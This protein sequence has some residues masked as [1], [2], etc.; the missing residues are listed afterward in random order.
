MSFKHWNIAPL[1]KDG[2]AALAEE[3]GIHPFLA[4]MLTLRGI[5]T[6]QEASAYLVGGEL[7]DD[8]F[9]FADMDAAVERI[10]RALDSGER[11]AVYGDYD[12]DGVTAT[13]LLYSFLAKNGADVLYYIPEREGEGYGMH[14][15]SVRTLAERGVR[16]II[17]VD[18][19][20]SAGEE[21]RLAAELGVDVV[22][23]DHHMPP[24][25]LPAAVAVVD[26][27]RAD[28]GSRCKDYAGVGVA[29]KLICALDGD[30]DAMRE[31][32]ADL[33]AL[34]TLAD[35]MPLDGENRKLV[36]YGLR[37]LT[38][39]ARP[40]LKQLVRVAGM[41]GRELDASAAAFT[42]APRI[43]AAGRMGSP[44]AALRLLLCEEEADAERLAEEIHAANA[45]RQAVEAEIRQQVQAVLKERPELLAD[46]VLVIAGE[47]W[48]PGV[49]GIIAARVMEQYGKPCLILSIRDGE[50][51]GSGR[52]LPGFSLFE[53]LREC[54]DV[55]RRY[56]GHELAA[57]VLLDAGDIEELR[58]RINAF[59]AEGHPLMPV[60][61][62]RLDCRLKPSQIDLEKLNLLAA[63]EPCGAGN[64]APLFGLFN[65]QL[66][67]VTPVGNGRHLRLSLSREGVRL[68]AMRFQ[69]AAA[70]FPVECGARLHL[71]VTLERNEYKGTVTP[72]LIVRDLRY[73]DTEEEEVLE[74]LRAADSLTRGDAL[75]EEQARDWTPDREQTA[76]LYRFLRRHKLWRGTLEQLLHAVRTDGFA[77]A[78]I[79]LALEAL[80]QAAL[81]TV[82]ENG[83]TMTIETLPAEGKAD[84]AATPVMRRLAAGRAAKV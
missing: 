62:L 55:L 4:L 37:R 81:I 12:C 79:R 68:S 42:L 48:H 77:G 11:M 51:K 17:T 6:A 75:T 20:I 38:E 73:A 63:L 66:D 34:G 52:S 72:S 5:T 50:A 27:H 7:E 84:L 15:Q 60:P 2:A 1:D 18:N 32:Y 3:C 13:A 9:E 21:V 76:V 61:E 33:V 70:D 31:E 67:N 26:P 83:D 57:G 16:L 22:I 39:G 41:S 10:Q 46:R 19:G 25:V 36:R 69:T 24:P 47:N 74:A 53:A 80:R 44:E 35:V 45:E 30:A 71:A 54:G 58:R 59:A 8:P 56:G 28:C 43:N 49:I 29:F 82:E 64:P 14:E 65:M 40:G 23:T 78:R